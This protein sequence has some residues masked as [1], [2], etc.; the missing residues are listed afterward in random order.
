MDRKSFIK[1]AALASTTAFLPKM[2][3]GSGNREKPVVWEVE[4]ISRETISRVFSELGGIPSLLPKGPGSSTVLLKPNLCLPDND[5]KA[6]TTSSVLID[7]LCRYLLDQGVSKI[8]V[9]DHT[10][11]DSEQFDDHPIVVK[12]RQHPGVKVMLTNEQRYFVPVEVNG[13]MLTSVEILKMLPK[14]DLFINIPTAKHHTATQ[15]SLGIKNLMGLIW[16]RSVFHTGLDLH[17]A[18]GDLAM[19]IKPDITI[20]DA[21]RVLLQGGPI[22]PGPVVED[23]RLFVSRDI[24]AVDSVVT[25]RYS[26]GGKSNSA[27]NVAHIW[28]AYENGM[29]EIDIDKIDIRK[30]TA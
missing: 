30:I 26:F 17:Q 18:V 8:I 10:L 16:D 21:S 28:A 23:N 27:L 14:I 7:E 2:I 11:Q 1:T 25:H 6:T 4:G 9:A 3:F 12:A 24:V 13:S 20:T 22:G 19:V 15:V 5:N 29:G